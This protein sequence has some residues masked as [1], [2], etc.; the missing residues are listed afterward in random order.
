MTTTTDLRDQILGALDPLFGSDGFARRK[1]QFAFRRQAS[2]SVT[3]SVHLNFGVENSTGT[4][5]VRPSVGARHASVERALVAAGVIAKSSSD[6]ATVARSLTPEPYEASIATG[7]EP[8]AQAIWSDWQSV[9]RQFAQELTEADH[10]IRLLSSGDPKDWGLHIPGMRDRLLVL[11]LD[12][13]GRHAE[14]LAVLDDL[15]RQPSERDQLIP[16]FAGFA[17]WIR[18]RG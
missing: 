8:V 16:A 9:G 5:V 13:T 6:R 1:G 14:A 2:T 12:T 7:A 17:T 4:L 11:F 3:Q 18:S 10:V 15:E